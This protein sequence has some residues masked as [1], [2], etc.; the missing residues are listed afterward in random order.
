MATTAKTAIVKAGKE[1][2]SVAFEKN[3]EKLLQAMTEK[4]QELAKECDKLIDRAQRGN[5]M[6]L[7]HIG[8]RVQDA[9]DE[10]KQG[11]Y[12]SNAAKQI[13]SYIPHFRGNVNELYAAARVAKTFDAE[14]IKENAELRVGDDYLQW[15]HLVALAT[16]DKPEDRTKMLDAVKAQALPV[17]EL[18]R[19][20]RGGEVK[21]KNVR[22]G[23]RTVTAPTSI[24]SGLEKMRASALSTCNYL[25][26]CQKSV[27]NRIASMPVTEVSDALVAK[28]E[29][30]KVELGKLSEQIGTANTQLDACLER[31]KDALAQKKAATPEEPAAAPK[32]GGKPAAKVTAAKTPAAKPKAKKPKAKKKVKAG[33]PAPATATA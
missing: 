1:S 19:R 24:I 14:F 27:F 20:I 5:I 28:L 30:D 3:R 21:A 4:T 15:G 16:I 8:V 9:L 6:A 7:Y 22:N 29:A 17:N 11:E 33:R 26:M 32:K 2:A 18:L 12:G 25:Q 13:A 23:G 31:A 10:A